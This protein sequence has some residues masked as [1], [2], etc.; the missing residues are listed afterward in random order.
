MRGNERLHVGCTIAPAGDTGQAYSGTA[1]HA[2]GIT[3]G[4]HRAIGF[5]MAQAVPAVVAHLQLRLQ[6][7]A[8][9]GIATQT[10]RVTRFHRA[11][12]RLAVITLRGQGHA[13]H[14]VAQLRTLH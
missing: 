14:A 13:L 7:Q 4:H 3:R 8:A 1:E 6:E 10:Q 2:I 12:P 11:L 5:G 9:T